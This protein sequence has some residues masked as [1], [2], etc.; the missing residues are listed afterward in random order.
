M[1]AENGVEETVRFLVRER[2]DFVEVPGRH[3]SGES[4]GVRAKL[5]FCSRCFPR[6]EAVMCF[7][8]IRHFTRVY[9]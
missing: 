6:Q 7:L 5:E 8:R 4:D 1:G 2:D 3:N 9:G